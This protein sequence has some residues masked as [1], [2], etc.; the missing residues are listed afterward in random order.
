[1]TV[2]VMQIIIWLSLVGG[3]VYVIGH[4]VSKYW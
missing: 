1:M 4:F 2:L 3:S